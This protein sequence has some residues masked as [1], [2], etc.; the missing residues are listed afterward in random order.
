LDRLESMTIFVRVVERGSIS[1]AAEEFRL[2]GTMV[3]HH[4]R[5]LET[6][7]G[8]RL[9]NRTTRRQSLT[10]LGQHY[11]ER[12]RRIL[13]DVADAEAI[14]AELHEH[15]R[16][17]LRVLAAVSFGVH[18]LAPACVDYRAAHPDVAIDL[19]VTDRTDFVDEGLTWWCVS[20]SSRTRR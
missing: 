5:A 18:A 12:C 10:E 4:I 15:A 1:A 16:G 14:G 7:L 9:L 11:Y 2:T 6:L 8:G 20:A 13:A 17:R 19:V 3:G